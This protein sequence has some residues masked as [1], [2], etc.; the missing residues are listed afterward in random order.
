M[1]THNNNKMIVW[2]FTFCLSLIRTMDLKMIM[3]EPESSEVFESLDGRAPSLPR[4]AV[5]GCSYMKYGGSRAV[6]CFRQG[7]HLHPPIVCFLFF[8]RTRF[9]DFFYFLQKKTLLLMKNQ[10]LWRTQIKNP[11][12]GAQLVFEKM[13]K[14]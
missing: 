6:F 4:G 11:L 3:L 2:F 9:Q 12:F 14:N 13:Q 10:H 1:H 7:G 8:E 5:R